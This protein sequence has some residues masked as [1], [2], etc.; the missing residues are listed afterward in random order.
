[1]CHRI[2]LFS[3]DYKSPI[4]LP[5]SHLNQP[6]LEKESKKYQVSKLPSPNNTSHLGPSDYPALL[7]LY[8][9]TKR[10]SHIV[11]LSRSYSYCCMCVCLCLLTSPLNK[12]QCILK[13]FYSFTPPKFL[14]FAPANLLP[15]AI[16]FELNKFIHSCYNLRIP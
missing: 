5:P 3:L 6:V 8:T 1:M 7:A 13:F 15:N 10:A 9:I 14:P 16:K 11:T 12:L 4:V 2:E